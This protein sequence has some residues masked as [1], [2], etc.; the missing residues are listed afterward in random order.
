MTWL[1]VAVGVVVIAATAMAV[2]GRWQPRGLAAGRPDDDPVAAG[3][4]PKFDVVLRGYRM[5]QVDAE[6]ARLRSG[7]AQPPGV[8]TDNGPGSPPTVASEAPSAPE[9]AAAR[10]DQP[11]SD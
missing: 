5:D 2:A 1:F 3:D 6:L 7:R 11:A 8:A 4:P 10:P 9:S